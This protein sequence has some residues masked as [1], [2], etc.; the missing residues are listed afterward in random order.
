MA[1][2]LGVGQQAFILDHRDRL[3][4]GAACERVAAEGR[5]VIAGPEDVGR[6]A[7]RDH[8]ADRH[9]AGKSL[10][11]RHDIG[12]YAG[13]VMREPFSGTAH[14]ALNLVDHQQPAL[15]I[16]ERADGLQVLDARGRDAT[17]ALN[18][19]EENRHDVGPLGCDALDRCEIVQWHA[20]EPGHERPEA[21]LH[22]GIASRR[23]GR[24]R[25]PVK[26]VFID[27]DF[28]ILDAAIVA[29]LARDLER[30]FVRFEPRVAEEHTVHAGQRGELVGQR[31]LQA[32]LV[33]VGRVN[34]LARLV[35]DRG[36][37]ARVAVAERIDRDTRET[38]E[39]LATAFVPQP[40][41]FSMCE[42]HGEIRVGVHQ[43]RRRI[44]VIHVIA[45]VEK[46]MGDVKR[47][48]RD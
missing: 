29:V 18:R 27:D 7:F 3:E 41:A 23:Q 35:G 28:G 10:G 33:Y 30:R 32:D 20:Y 1:G 17:F 38:V 8:G 4:R 43:M 15:S 25:A 37:Q 26:G 22:L 13:P 45:R 44:G 39:V 31:L 36:D 11:H 12:L 16:A 46:W 5:A 24:D 19:F 40:R 47:F 42:V 48:A 2:L 9:A 14:A 6:L 34:Q 21:L